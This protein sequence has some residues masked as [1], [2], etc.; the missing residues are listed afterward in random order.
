EV[1]KYIDVSPSYIKSEDIQRV[2]ISFKVEKTW[3]AKNNID[4]VVLNRFSE[5]RWN[6][7][8]T[9][10]E[11]ED[12]QYVYYSAESPGLSVFGISGQVQAVTTTTVPS[13]T[14]TTVPATIAPTTTAPP[15]APTTT[16]PPAEEPKKGICGP[17]VVLLIAM[18][19]PALSRIR[20][21]SR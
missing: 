18:L 2:K 3:I 15:A 12:G 8:T 10:K 17:T 19:F 4:T 5:D 7:L 20:R 6:A 14:T 13:V 1:F 16:A 9:A 21:R 11:S